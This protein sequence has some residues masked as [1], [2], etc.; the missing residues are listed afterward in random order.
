MLSTK[1]LEK[2]ISKELKKEPSISAH[3]LHFYEGQADSEEGIYAFSKGGRYILRKIEKGAI[4]DQFETKNERDLL[5]VIICNTS[6]NTILQYAKKHTPIGVDFRRA[7]FE[8]TI[9]I[10]S[11]FGADFKQKAEREIAEILERYPY[12]DNMGQGTDSGV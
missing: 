7:M 8:K 1:Q 3:D 4:I 11:Y 5:W 10:L 6:I 2:Y 9:E 12:N